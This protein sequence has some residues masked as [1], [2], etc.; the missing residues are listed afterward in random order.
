MKVAITGA[1]GLIGTALT[2]H[3]TAVGHH[4]VAVTRGTP[5]PGEIGW[6]PADG[7]IDAPAFVGV[8]AVVHLAGAGI[9]ARRWNA[10]YK[11]T[12]VDSRVDGTT[13]LARALA[14]LAGGPTVLISGSAIGFYGDRGDEQLTAESDPG[15]GFLPDLVQQ[16][17]SATQPAKD[18]GVR[19]AH[20]RS[21][22]VLSADGGALGKMLPLFKLGLGGRFGDGQQW[23]SWISIT[24]E[25]RA[26]E[27][28]L[29]HDVSGPVNL[30]AP[31]PVRNT[32][33]ADTLGE[34]LG[35]PTLLPVPAFGPRLLLGR[36]MADNLLFHSQR[37][38]P[39]AL[40]EAGF[41]FRSTQL[42]DALE[43][44]LGR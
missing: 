20:I 6:S 39:V 7:D 33:F 19:V 30:T 2:A 16:W 27:F 41:L 36:E 25:V 11:R 37:A 44:V 14:D 4:V 24:D 32:E 38:T 31:G 23:M 17:E 10:A 3:L 5:G 26:I 42:A 8:D 13:L 40:V 28:L 22:V 1:S 15:T 18:A 21:G 35:R 12:L 29:D 34:V 9:G 43:D